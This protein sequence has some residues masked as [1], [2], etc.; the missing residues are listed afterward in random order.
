MHRVV[1]PFA[2]LTEFAG[3]SVENEIL[4]PIGT[5]FVIESVEKKT[6]ISNQ[7]Y[8]YAKLSLCVD[9]D[10]VEQRSNSTADIMI[11]HLIELCRR[12]PSDSDIGRQKIFRQCRK[13]YSSSE[14]QLRKLEEFSQSYSPSNTIMWYTR[15]S[16]LY[17]TLNRALRTNNYRIIINFSFFIL[18]LHAQLV[19]TYE[20][21][22]K[23]LLNQLNPN[24]LTVYRGQ[25]ITLFELDKIKR[26]VGQLITF[27]TFP[28]ASLSRD[29]ALIY[30]G[31]DTLQSNYK[32]VLFKIDIEVTQRI[33][34]PFANVEDFSF[35]PDENEVLF[36]AGTIFRVRAVQQIKDE[37]VWIVHLK[38]C[39]DDDDQVRVIKRFINAV[40]SKID[41]IKQN[42][43]G[44]DVVEGL[45]NLLRS[46]NGM[47]ITPVTIDESIPMYQQNICAP[48]S[49]PLL[50]SLNQRL[51]CPRCGKSHKNRKRQVQLYR[52]WLNQIGGIF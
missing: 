3:W 26:N 12:L 49:S 19:K 14:S 43:Y 20:D 9:Y 11:L 10:L 8:W 21:F 31:N 6:S 28:S 37:N 24:V 46:T 35:F 16:F 2:C 13:Y 40:L 42:T 15:D 5:M 1:T 22:S 25:Q 36:S 29:V 30:A 44:T 52:Q 33:T 27:R 47:R 34:E 48:E 4:F 18:D 51:N 17:R 23:L 32:S 38:M 7:E 45:C 39:N 50:N 41:E